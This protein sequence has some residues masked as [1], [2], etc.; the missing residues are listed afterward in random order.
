MPTCYSVNHN[1]R[2]ETAATYRQN[3]C[4]SDFMDYI[5]HNLSAVYVTL[6]NICSTLI[7]NVNNVIV[8]L[9]IAKPIRKSEYYIR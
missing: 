4:A 2:S 1:N 9:N 8:Q 7:M 6:Y 3:M 5:V